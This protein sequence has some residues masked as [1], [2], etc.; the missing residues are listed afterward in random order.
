MNEFPVSITSILSLI[1]APLFSAWLAVQFSIRQFQKEH[2]WEKKI[3]AYSQILEALENMLFY[4]HKLLEDSE[5]IKKLPA[6]NE[7]RELRKKVSESHEVI[8]K[9]SRIGVLF[10]SKA[11][12]DRLQAMERQI[13]SL[14]NKESLVE[15]LEQCIPI[16]T[17]A[18]AD[19]RTFA[20][21]DLNV[22]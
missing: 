5:G 20:K 4:E 7:G 13:N 12:N 19:V 15:W 11:T 8:N 9:A 6:D 2:W 21:K 22:Q 18:L 16:Y 10:V 3:E 14:P 17:D 1:V